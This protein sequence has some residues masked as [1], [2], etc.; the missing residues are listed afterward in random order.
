MDFKCCG[1]WRYLRSS[2]LGLN[3]ITFDG[4]E[5]FDILS[6]SVVWNVENKNDILIELM[7]IVF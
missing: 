5:I 3:E 6:V 4:G 1:G 2:G 7:E